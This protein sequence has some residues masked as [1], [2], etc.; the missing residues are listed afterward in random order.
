M[1]LPPCMEPK[2]VKYCDAIDR[3]ATAG[4]C[5]LLLGCPGENSLELFGPPLTSHIYKKNLTT[6]LIITLYVC[7]LEK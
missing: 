6:L 2:P 4:E 1:Q 5:I 7:Q 3:R